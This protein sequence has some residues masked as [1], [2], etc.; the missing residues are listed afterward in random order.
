MK[1]RVTKYGAPGRR[2]KQ[3]EFMKPW[4]TEKVNG[5][6]CNSEGSPQNGAKAR[7]KMTKIAPV[8]LDSDYNGRQIVHKVD[9]CIEVQQQ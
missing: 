1:S 4:I 7:D 8:F 3:Q 2:G 6:T 9:S 5:C